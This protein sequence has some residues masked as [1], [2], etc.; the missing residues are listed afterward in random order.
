[1]PRPPLAKTCLGFPEHERELDVDNRNQTPTPNAPVLPVHC[2]R[3]R[4][5][6]LNRS[7]VQRWLYMADQTEM[8]ESAFPVSARNETGETEREES[9]KSV[10]EAVSLPGKKGNLA[11]SEE[12]HRKDSAVLPRP[13]EALCVCEPQ[14]VIRARANV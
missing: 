3:D 12:I 5:A 1:M 14:S 13:N 2:F 6:G 4:I 9:A 11:A 7:S 10:S 8:R